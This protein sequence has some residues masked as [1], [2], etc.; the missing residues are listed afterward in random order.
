[1]DVADG[2][3]DSLDSASGWA[4]WD[5]LGGDIIADVIKH[6][7]M[8]DAQRGIE[9]LQRAL[10]DFRTELADVR[11]DDDLDFQMDGFTSFGDWFFDGLIFDWMAMD[12]I[13]KS[14]VQIQNTQNQLAMAISK[15]QDMQSAAALELEE[16]QGQL[17]NLVSRA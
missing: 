9:Q 16:V 10:R 12:H 13:S 8:D 1:M 3:A 15:L 14:S 17:D 11:I 7:H 5:L 4:T 6:G 2:I